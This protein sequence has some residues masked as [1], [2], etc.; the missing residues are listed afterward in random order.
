[1]CN[2]SGKEPAFKGDAGTFYVSDLKARQESSLSEMV[3]SVLEKTILNGVM[4]ESHGEAL[5]QLK[6]AFDAQSKKIEAVLKTNS[7]FFI[8]KN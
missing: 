5:L 1:M 6:N 2:E 8:Q 4:N 7:K 3:D